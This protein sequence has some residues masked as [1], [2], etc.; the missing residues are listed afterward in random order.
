[1]SDAEPPAPRGPN[2]VP[3]LRR[4]GEAVK[5]IIGVV[6]S[7][8]QLKTQNDVLAKKVDELQRKSISKRPKLKFCLDLLSVL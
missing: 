6:H 4:L 3:M 7:V 8:E 5:T 1:M 2:V